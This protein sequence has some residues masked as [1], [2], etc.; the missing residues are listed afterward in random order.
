VKNWKHFVIPFVLTIIIF[1]IV[2]FFTSPEN[3]QYNDSFHHAYIGILIL[4]IIGLMYH[5]K[6][7]IN[8]IFFGIGLG[9]LIDEI[10]LFL[11]KGN[12]Y[13]KYWNNLSTYGTVILMI[14]IIAIYFITHHIKEKKT[15]S[16]S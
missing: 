16:F 7:R 12:G 10:F 14:I 11:S 4:I 15:K 1:R 13:Q 6:K 8:L 9:A 3:F 2:L 5:I